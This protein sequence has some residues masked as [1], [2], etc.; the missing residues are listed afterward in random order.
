MIK[1]I[2]LLFSYSDP[3]TWR[4]FVPVEEEQFELDKERQQIRKWMSEAEGRAL[5]FLAV[6][7]GGVGKSALINNL[8]ELDKGSENA[9]VERKKCHDATITTTSVSAHTLQL[10]RNGIDV[11]AFD[12][13]GF[14]DPN[15]EDLDII[16]Q[17]VRKTREHVDV[18]LYCASLR[19]RISREDYRICSLLTK[20][21][22]KSVWAKAIF[23]LTR[24]ND[25]D[26]EQKSADEY[27]QI[28]ANGKT[29]LQKAVKA[30]GVP[31]DVV[32]A[33]PVCTAGY[34]DPYLKQMEA[35]YKGTWQDRIYTEMI[36]RADP[37]TVPEFSWG[38]T[39]L[40]ITVRY[41]L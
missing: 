29:Q 37:E 18:F 13:S 3:D 30:A 5:H 31:E 21:F 32:A 2:F 1:G 9:A 41:T 34:T 38:E 22:G 7:R 17:I 14:Q 24:A 6:G 4:P 36:R 23:V 35:S 25:D 8:L 12:T 28:I 26:I 33:I 20:S 27:A 40:A 16:A 19:Q 11:V 39:I 15:I 10:H